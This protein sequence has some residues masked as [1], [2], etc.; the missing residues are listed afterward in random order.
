MIDRETNTFTSQFRDDYPYQDKDLAFSAKPYIK[1]FFS[2]DNLMSDYLAVRDCVCSRCREP[3]NLSIGGNVTCRSCGLNI[4]LTYRSSIVPDFNGFFYRTS[5]SSDR[6]MEKREKNQLETKIQIL[7]K[8]EWQ[9][10]IVNIV[11]RSKE[12]KEW[13]SVN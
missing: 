12:H 3:I 6:E 4:S 7:K 5:E 1:V 9:T 13:L 8:S 10:A 2:P 11:N